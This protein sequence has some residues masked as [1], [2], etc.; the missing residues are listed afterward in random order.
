MSEWVQV[1]LGIFVW[2]FFPALSSFFVTLQTPK[3]L[4]LLSGVF[5]CFRHV[6]DEGSDEYKIIMLNKRFLSFRVIKVCDTNN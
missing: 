1:S 2:K 6:L 3:H 5:V 4:A